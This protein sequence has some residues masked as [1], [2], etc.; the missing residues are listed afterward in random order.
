MNREISILGVSFKVK[1]IVLAIFIGLFMI[2][3]PYAIKN[4]IVSSYK[5]GLKS[6][7]KNLSGKKKKEAEEYLSLVSRGQLFPEEEH[8]TT[9]FMHRD[10][11]EEPWRFWPNTYK[12][13][14]MAR[15]LYFIFLAFIILRKLYE[16]DKLKFINPH[17]DA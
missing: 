13:W 15:N 11:F 2:Y 6:A 1:N 17:K 3:F 9:D 10:Y 4:V 12:V 5:E 7:I 8:D 14:I 16:A